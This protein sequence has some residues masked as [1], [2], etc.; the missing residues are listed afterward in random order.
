[1]ETCGYLC[2]RQLLLRELLPS[3]VRGRVFERNPSALTI[4]RDAERQAIPLQFEIADVFLPDLSGTD[5]SFEVMNHDV[6]LGLV[7]VNAVIGGVG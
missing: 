3:Q 6:V 5:R 7:G 1:M 2:P 4:V